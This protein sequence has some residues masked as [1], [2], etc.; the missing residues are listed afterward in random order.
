PRPT[1]PPRPPGHHAPADP[2]RAER[3]PRER[4]HRG[5]PDGVV[6]VRT[7]VVD[8]GGGEGADDLEL[9][10][11][12]VDAVREERA[13]VDRGERREPLHDPPPL[14]PHPVAPAPPSLP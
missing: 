14:P 7:R 12:E 13:F 4:P 3:Q 9:L 6:H 10:L 1:P 5:V 8:G 11:L 2:V